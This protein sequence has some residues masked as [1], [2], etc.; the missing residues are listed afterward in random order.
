MI[1]FNIICKN[2]DVR[3]L[4][5]I[6]STKIGKLS[7]LTRL[8][9][10]NLN[11]C[12]FIKMSGPNRLEYFSP[13]NY[14]ASSLTAPLWYRL[15]A[16]LANRLGWKGLLGTYSLTYYT[17]LSVTEVKIITALGPRVIVTTLHF[18]SILKTDK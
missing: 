14:E 18:L 1:V 12:F 13:T 4:D 5:L 8:Q 10:C 3:E 6:M 7:C 11:N 2:P 17:H 16:L 9:L 15:L